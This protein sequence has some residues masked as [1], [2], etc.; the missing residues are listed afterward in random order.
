MEDITGLDP[1]SAGKPGERLGSDEAPAAQVD[2][3]LQHDGQGISAESSGSRLA[4]EEPWRFGKEGRGCLLRAA[5]ADHAG[6]FPRWCSR[7]GRPRG[8]R[9]RAARW[10]GSD[11]M[12]NSG[13][14]VEATRFRPARFAA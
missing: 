4:G 8:V 3:G 2:D 10:E 9:R 14:V 7:R 1:G 12:V 13:C 5:P 6:T 11:A